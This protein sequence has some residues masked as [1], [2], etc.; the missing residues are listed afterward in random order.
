L[1]EIGEALA[2]LPVER[3]P[4]KADWRRLSRL[5]R[6]RLDDRIAALERLRDDLDGCIGCGCLSLRSCALFNPGDVASTRGTGPRYLFGDAVPLS[7]EL[8]RSI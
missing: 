6:T 4:T 5:W 1:D 2:S 3:S 7:R 8:R